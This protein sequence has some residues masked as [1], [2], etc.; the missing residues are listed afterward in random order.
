MRVYLLKIYDDAC[1]NNAL[2]KQLDFDL[3]TNKWRSVM[4]A[5][6]K[7]NSMQHTVFSPPYIGDC[8]QGYLYS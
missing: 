7:L 2:L 3:L 6:P 4:Q 8:N 5:D 1:G